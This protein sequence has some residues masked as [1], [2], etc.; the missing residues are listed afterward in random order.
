MPRSRFL[1]VKKSSDLLLLMS[2]LYDIDNGSLTLSKQRSFPTTP[3]V[4]L[5]SSFDKASSNVSA[6]AN[7]WS[8]FFQ[9]KDFLARFHGIPDLLELDHLTVSG[10][11]TFGKDVSLKVN[12]AY[13]L[14]FP[15][16]I[17]LLGQPVNGIKQRLLFSILH[18]EK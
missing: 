3:L 11:V 2:N 8:L 18:I 10:D 16:I 15:I 5:G 4:K 12:R 14:Y 13:C 7:L 1:P 9:V 17:V 6:N